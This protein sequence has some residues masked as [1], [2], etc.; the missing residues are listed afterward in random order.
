MSQSALQEWK[1]I[2]KTLREAR[3]GLLLFDFD[4]TLTPIVTQRKNARLRG[5]TRR[6]LRTL[7]KTSRFTVGVV[8]GRTLK[9]VRQLINLP[10]LIYAGNH[11]LDIAGCGLRFVS[12]EGLLRAPVL[13]Q[14]VH[15]LSKH[16][17]NIPGVEMED[18]NLSASIHFRR[19]PQRYLVRL[20]A[21][22]RRHLIPVARRHHFRLMAGKK[23]VDIVPSL[24]WNKGKAVDWIRKHFHPSTVV[25]YAGDDITDEDVF[26][27]LHR[28]DI[29]I[30]LGNG[31]RTLARYRLRDSRD[32]QRLLERL[33]Y[34][35]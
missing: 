31:N 4:G 24:A 16:L 18:K 34:E 26:R 1:T 10:D 19:T 28:E 20:R 22:L 30:H 15:D 9:Q 5:A 14:M 3:H 17:K 7:S 29:A 33:A 32:T 6:A 27:Q 25:L 8:S 23:T 13:Q 35:S 2:E 12:G 21:G 11:G